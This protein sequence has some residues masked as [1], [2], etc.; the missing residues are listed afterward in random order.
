MPVR[1]DI[2][3][4]IFVGCIIFSF[5]LVSSWSARL[6]KC[7][8]DLVKLGYE[9]WKAKNVVES[10]DISYAFTNLI[11]N[12]YYSFSTFPHLIPRQ[13]KLTPRIENYDN[14]CLFCHID[15]STKRKDDFAFWIFF[16]FKGGSAVGL[17]RWC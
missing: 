1:F 17:A 4:W 15:S 3:K 2:A 11:A 13:W 10:R 9:T 16:T 6:W 8:T 5:L 12:D 14:F 7:V